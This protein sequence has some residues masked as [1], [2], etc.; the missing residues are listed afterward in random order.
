MSTRKMVLIKGLSGIFSCFATW[1][2]NYFIVSEV[3]SRFGIYSS[4]AQIILL[5]V[6]A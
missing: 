4:S 2:V 3:E 6:L 5:V 1:F